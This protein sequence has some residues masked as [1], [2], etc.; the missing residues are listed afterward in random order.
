MKTVIEM[1]RE[2]TLLDSRDD[3]NSVPD[4]YR[5]AINAFAELVRADEKARMAEQ[6]AQQG[7]LSEEWIAYCWR[8]SMIGPRIRYVEYLALVRETERAHGIKENT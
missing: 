4:E 3:W 1:A 2:A 7:P 8:K 5:E 6:P